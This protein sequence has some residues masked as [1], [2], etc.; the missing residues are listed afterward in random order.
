MILPSPEEELSTLHA[1][2]EAG[3][4][5]GCTREHTCTVDGLP[6]EEYLRVIRRM[7]ELVLESI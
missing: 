1:V 4:V 5:D 6:A 2:H 7:H 3:A